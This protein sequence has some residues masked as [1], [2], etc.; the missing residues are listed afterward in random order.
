MSMKLIRK[1]WAVALVAGFVGTMEPAVAATAVTGTGT[2]PS[3]LQVVAHQDDDLLFMNPDLQNAINA[4]GGRTLTTVYLTAGEGSYAP[5]PAT[6]PGVTTAVPKD[7]QDSVLKRE[8]YAYCRAEGARQAWLRMLG[9]PAGTSWSRSALSVSLGGGSRQVEVDT[10]VGAN[11]VT[12]NLVFVNLPDDGD[13]SSTTKANPADTT[14]ANHSLQRLWNDGSTRATVVPA[15]SMVAASQTYSR[16]DLVGLLSGLLREFKPTVVRT[17]DPA[18]DAR[19]R[20]WE[21]PLGDH[22]DHVVAALAAG[23]A[24]KAGGLGSRVQIVQ[25]RDYNTLFSEADLS[26]AA[27][28]AK[29]AAWN[30]YTPF[31]NSSDIKYDAAYPAWNARQF[32]RFWRGTNWVGRN[33]DG[34][35]QA[36]SVQGGGL[37]SWSE[38]PDGTWSGPNWT[39]D[40]GFALAPGVSVTR[41]ADGRLLVSALRIETGEITTLSQ[42][43]P[44]GGWEDHWVSL[45]RP[46]T[47]SG[48]T[49]Q[50]VT[51][52][53]KDGRVQ[54]FVKNA[55]GGVSTIGQTTPGGTFSSWSTVDTGTGVQ[56]GLAAAT[57]SAGRIQLFAYSYTNPQFTGTPTVTGSIL[58]WRQD[59]QNSTAFTRQAFAFREPAGPPTV[60]KN[61][62]GRLDVFYRTTAV[63]ATGSVPAADAGSV[64][65]TWQ[66]VDGSWS[67]TTQGLA[68]DGG[69]GP[70]AAVSAPNQDTVSTGD[71]RITLFEHNAGG[72][73][74]TQK[75]STPNG[76]YGA[77]SDRNGFLVGEPAAATDRTGRVLVFAVGDDGRLQI[78]KQ[79]TPGASQLFSAWAPVVEG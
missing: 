28:A 71:G 1:C 48:P 20:Y 66:R 59:A 40:P 4:G 49:G 61:A 65:H 44:N 16:S 35:L 41:N 45:G 21:Y 51:A 52:A 11:G 13:G 55:T 79:Q 78:M 47:A 9:A 6:A 24:L 26:P 14:S 68:G 37:L 76:G 58:N 75:Q 62:D 30:A 38:S 57:D 17:Q 54:I 69:I 5:A 22:P 50:P 42:A 46:S 74:S 39:T 7:C 12:A 32:P 77:W 8:E 43:S 23:E 72:S 31:D 67:A 2:L 73:V 70:V 36:F 19:L 63:P 25:Y 64:E 3:Y 27:S 53:N 15:G 10:V 33:Q 29:K 34:T 18:P 60:A 56:D